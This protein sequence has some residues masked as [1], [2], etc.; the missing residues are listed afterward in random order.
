MEYQIRKTAIPPAMRGEW[1]SAVWQQAETGELTH[2]LPR[3]SEHHPRVRFRLLYDEQA[4]YVIFRVEDQYVRSV[5]TAL[6]GPVCT[7]S[8][9]EF[10]V[11]PGSDTGYIN[12]EVNC[13]GS[14]LAYYIEDC[15][16]VNGDFKKRTALASEDAALMQIYHSMPE[17]VKPEITT[18]VT[19]VNELRIPFVLFEKYM[20]PLGTP[21]GQQWTANF[22][23]CA[24]ATSHPHWLTWAPVSGQNF[25]QPGY[26]APIIFQK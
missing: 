10:F 21:D 3:S 19:W 16:I 7:D 17:V 8:C 18:P 1:D 4:L 25:H 15:T 5:V 20:G 11:Q 12:F 13:G 6:H 2:F 26:F 22:Y 23:K 9:T 14:M 24:D